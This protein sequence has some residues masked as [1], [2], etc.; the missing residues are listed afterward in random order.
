MTRLLF[1]LYG[2]DSGL[3]PADLF[4]RWVEQETTEA[5]LGAQLNQLFS[6]L[7]T[8]V[9]KRSSRMGDLMAQFPYVNG[10]VF[11]DS[12]PELFFPV[13]SREALLK[14]MPL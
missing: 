8:P 13:G 4:H 10:G 3:W 1:L 12:F 14:R 11:K 9:K 6:I 5:S 7:N 2:D